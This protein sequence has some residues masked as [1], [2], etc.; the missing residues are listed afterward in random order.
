LG[1][2]LVFDQILRHVMAS[3]CFPDCGEH[4]AAHAAGT[5]GQ[6]KFP[7]PA[8]RQQAQNTGTKAPAM[9]TSLAC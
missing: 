7:E 5:K 3:H 6:G 1:G 9:Q 2:F 4:L 8:A